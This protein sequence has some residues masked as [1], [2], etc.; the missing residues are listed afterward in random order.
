[1]PTNSKESIY[2]NKNQVQRLCELYQQEGYIVKV[3]FVHS[4]KISKVVWIFRGELF[5]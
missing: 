4:Y 3:L 1:M 2:F 5:H